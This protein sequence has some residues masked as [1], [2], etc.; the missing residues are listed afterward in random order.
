MSGCI[1]GGGGKRGTQNDKSYCARHCGMRDE[2]FPLCFHIVI[3]FRICIANC[4]KPPGV[5][6][7]G[8]RRWCTVQFFYLSLEAI[9][10]RFCNKYLREST[11]RAEKRNV[12]SERSNY[13]WNNNFY[14]RQYI[15]ET[16]IHMTLLASLC[17]TVGYFLRPG[18]TCRTRNNK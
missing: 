7:I 11:N 5:I 6:E 17:L 4:E 16:L 15:F 3:I 9:I 18:I 12:H 1:P 14:T 13:Y 2:E 8:H 10:L